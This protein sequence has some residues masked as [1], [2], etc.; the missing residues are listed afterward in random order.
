MNYYLS[1]TINNLTD[2][3][4]TGIIT[5]NVYS[6]RYSKL[7]EEQFNIYDTS[8]I[9]SKTE[10]LI[11]EKHCVLE[12]FIEDGIVLE[13]ISEEF[14]KLEDCLPITRIKK[15]IFDDSEK[16]SYLI[17]NITARTAY[18]PSR[19]IDIN[20]ELK[21][22]PEYF[23]KENCIGCS[24]NNN[25]IQNLKSYNELLG[26]IAV[27]NTC[28]QENNYNYSLQ[29]LKV[30]SEL[31]VQLKDQI[32]SQLSQKAFPSITPETIKNTV[33]ALSEEGLKKVA[34]KD[35][36]KIKQDSILKTISSENLFGDS[37]VLYYLL[38]YK[39]N[40][41]DVGRFNFQELLF[42]NY[43]DIKPDEKYAV[44]FYYGHYKGY[45]AFAKSYNSAS[46]AYPI[47]FKLDSRFDYAVIEAIYHYY[48]SNEKNNKNIQRILD[49]IYPLIK[50][51]KPCRAV[52]YYIEDKFILQDYRPS[53]KDI[54]AYLMYLLKRIFN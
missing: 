2:Y 11:E 29:F 51:T 54:S 24:L 41:D 20:K 5:P 28:K 9:L 16:A 38:Y 21:R 27:L 33:K 42:S 53:Y 31:S 12:L 3:F 34:K 22:I 46:Q 43:R 40:E 39:L 17:T 45:S 7:K 6:S 14:Y 25:T 35:N 52:G 19:L 32:Q 49:K 10:I 48:F 4:N 13:K 44:A 50:E 23:S 26:A 8:L 30:I 1:I 15:I 36:I 18:I 37:L 47:K